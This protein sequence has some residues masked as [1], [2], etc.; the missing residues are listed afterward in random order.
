MTKNRQVKTK[1]PR[2]S[3][4]EVTPD[5]QKGEYLKKIRKEKKLS[6]DAVHEATKIPL[7]VLRAIEE[8]YTVRTLSEFYYKGFLKIYAS[9][10]EIDVQDV[11]DDY[12]TEVLP[13]HIEGEIEDFDIKQWF[14]GL[15]SRERKQQIVIV[16]GGIVALFIL[17][18]LIT[19]LIRFASNRPAKPTQIERVKNVKQTQKKKETTPQFE[20]KDTSKTSANIVEKK[21]EVP[22]A[23]PASTVATPVNIVST[24]KVQKDVTL[25]VRARKK[26]WL[27]VKADERVVFQSTLK[28]GAVETW[29]AMKSI[30]ISGRNINQLEFE[31]NGKMIG[32]LGRRDRKAKKVT[33]TKDGLKVSK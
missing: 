23:V 1:Y 31:L 20:K 4:S 16:A 6:L 18:Q 19:F 29:S 21:K 27:R 24:P 10:L 33:V 30:E 2:E 13:E 25:T 22:I 11:V 28:E 32:T 5:T 9:Y 26:S 7:D 17:F 3:T 15:V 12:K 14:S 8:G